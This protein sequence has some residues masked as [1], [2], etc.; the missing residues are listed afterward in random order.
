[1]MLNIQQAADM[2]DRAGFLGAARV[3]RS[4]PFRR[5]QILIA[6]RPALIR[7]VGDVMANRILAHAEMAAERE[8]HRVTGRIGE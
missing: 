7:A 2:I 5:H 4:Q 3:F 6:I 8:R 1:M